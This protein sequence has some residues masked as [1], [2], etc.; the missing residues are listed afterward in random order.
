M[1]CRVRETLLCLLLQSQLHALR[2]L[3]VVLHEQLHVRNRLLCCVL[4]SQLHTLRLPGL[5]LQSQFQLRNRLLCLHLVACEED[6]G[7]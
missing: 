2:L 3:H 6:A 1:G 5:V 4:Q 7:C